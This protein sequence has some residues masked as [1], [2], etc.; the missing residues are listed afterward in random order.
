MIAPANAPMATPAMAPFDKSL[1]PPGV[2]TADEEVGVVVVDDSGVVVEVIVLGSVRLYSQD[3]ENHASY[4][5]SPLL[6]HVV[7]RT[8]QAGLRCEHTQLEVNSVQTF[9]PLKQL[10]A[11]LGMPVRST[12]GFPGH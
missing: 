10:R 6:S 7:V 11:Q 2:V 9:D 1:P 3:F 8:V 4:S 5:A 12:S